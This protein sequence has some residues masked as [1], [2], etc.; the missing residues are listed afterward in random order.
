MKFDYTGAREAGYSDGDIVGFLEQKGAKFDFGAARAAGYSD[1]D[2]AGYIESNHDQVFGA[3]EP[4]IVDRAVT[5]GKRIAKSTYIG[6]KLALEEANPFGAKTRSVTG[7]P[8]SEKDLRAAQRENF[9]DTREAPLSPVDRAVAERAGPVSRPFIEA[10]RRNAAQ[11]Q[12]PTQLTPEQEAQFKPWYADIA[13]KGGLDPNPDDPRHQYDY[14]G[15]FLAG[16]QP[17]EDGHLDSRFKAPGHPNRFVDG[18]DT[19]TGQPVDESV[20]A[21]TA[22]AVNAQQSKTRQTLDERGV[23]PQET[24]E[25][26]LSRAGRARYKTVKTWDFNRSE[27]MSMLKDAAEAGD[28]HAS[29]ALKELTGTADNIVEAAAADLRKRNP[30]LAQS[31]SQSV[32]TLGPMYRQA[33]GGAGMYIGAAIGD[34]LAIHGGQIIAAEAKRDLERLAKEHGHGLQQQVANSVTQTLGVM[35][36]VIASSPVFGGGVE[37]VLGT[38]SSVAGAQAYAEGLDDGL[39]PN[40]AATYAGLTALIEYATEKIPTT[41]L[42]KK[43]PSFVKKAAHVLVR[44]YPSEYAATALEAALDKLTKNPEMTLREFSQQLAVTTLAVPISTGALAAGTHAA[45]RAIGA[46]VY[47]A[48][49]KNT[50]LPPAA[51]APLSASAVLGAP[52]EQAPD[53]ASGSATPRQPDPGGVES[54]LADPKAIFAA[55]TQRPAILHTIQQA[56][57]D[58]PAVAPE[59][60]PD[61]AAALKAME[62]DPRSIFAIA[63]QHP[64]IFDTI[65]KAAKASGVQATAPSPTEAPAVPPAASTQAPAYESPQQSVG[66]AHAQAEADRERLRDREIERLATE[67]RKHRM[68]EA[69]SLELARAEA[70]GSGVRPEHKST[71]EHALER[72]TERAA[73][74]VARGKPYGLSDKTLQHI[75]GKD[76]MIGERARAELARRAA[77]RESQVGTTGGSLLSRPAGIARLQAAHPQVPMQA[78]APEH[79]PSKAKRIEK[80]L[81]AAFNKKVVFVKADPA[82]FEGQVFTDDPSTVYINVDANRSLRKVTGHELLH[83]LKRTNQRVYANLLRS[84]RQSIDLDKAGA[85]ENYYGE[86]RPAKGST[87]HIEEMVGDIF[88][89]MMDDPKFWLKVFHAS[90]KPLVKKLYDAIRMLLDVLRMKLRIGERRSGYDTREI[91][92]DIEAVRKA[93]AQAYA[94][95]QSGAETKSAPAREA[96]VALQSKPDIHVEV[97]KRAEQTRQRV[98]DRD[99]DFR[100]SKGDKILSNTGRSYEILFR[101]LVGKEHDKPAYRVKSLDGE[102]SFD[103]HEEAAS[104]QLDAA[105]QSLFSLPFKR[106]F[107]ERVAA[108]ERADEKTKRRIAAEPVGVLKALPQALD[109]LKR[110]DGTRVFAKSGVIGNVSTIYEKG[111]GL[112]RSA[113]EGRTPIPREM[114]SNLDDY[115]KDPLAV[116]SPPKDHPHADRVWLLLGKLGREYASVVIDPKSQYGGEPVNM[117]VSTTPRTATA[118]EYARKQGRVLYEKEAPQARST[119]GERGVEAADSNPA[120]GEGEKPGGA[121]QTGMVSKTLPSVKP[122]VDEKAHEA[123]TSPKNDKP[124]PTQ[125]QKQAGNYAKGHV[126]VA[127]M[128]I[129]I[130]NPEGSVRTFIRPDGVIG[131]TRL[132]AHYG[133][134][135][136]T[137]GADGDHLDIFIKPGTPHAYEGPVFVADQTKSDS[138]RF[139]EHKVLLGWESLA[140]A[141]A[142]YKENYSKGWDGLESIVRFD[143]VADFKTWKDEGNLDRRAARDPAALLSRPARRAPELTEE[144]KKDLNFMKDRAYDAPIEETDPLARHLEQQNQ[145]L[146]QQAERELRGGERPG[147]RFYPR[148][149]WSKR[150]NI[151]DWQSAD[152]RYMIEQLPGRQFVLKIDGQEKFLGHDRMSAIHAAIM[153][154]H[155]DLAAGKARSPSESVSVAAQ[156]PEPVRQR[157]AQAWQKLASFKTIFRFPSSAKKGIDGILADMGQ[158]KLVAAIHDH[159]GDVNKFFKIEFFDGTSADL[160]LH[161]DGTAHL[162]AAELNEG[163]QLGPVLYQAVL[164]WAK[165]NK[166]VL[167]PDPAGLSYINSYRRTEQMLSAALRLGTSAYMRPHADQGLYGWIE[168]PKSQ[169]DEDSNIA[170]MAITSMRSVMEHVP[171]VPS[172]RYDF[173][174]RRFEEPPN[175]PILKADLDALGASKPARDIGAGRSTLARAIFTQSLLSDPQGADMLIEGAVT[176]ALVLAGDTGQSLALYSNPGERFEKKGPGLAKGAVLATAKAGTVIARPLAAALDIANTAADFVAKGPGKLLAYPTSRLYDR[177]VSGVSNFMKKGELR[178]QIAHGTTAD[179]GLPEPYL[180]KRDDRDIDIQKHLRQ[181]KQMIDH[182]AALDDAESMV[183]YQWM[184]E[185]PSTAEEARLLALLPEGSKKTL[186]AMKDFIDKLGREA[187]ALGLMSQETYDRNAMAYLHRSYK[188]YEVENPQA[189]ASSQ[190]AKALRADSFRGRGLRDD[191]ALSRLPGVAKGDHYVRLEE[192]AAQPTG[193]LGRL[194]R[195][196]YIRAGQPIPASYSTWRNDGVWEARFIDKAGQVGL[197]RD[198]TRDERERLGEIREVRYAFARTMIGLVHDIETARFLKW[199]MENY[200][201]SDEGGVAEK[202]GTVAD[203][204]DK[205]TTLKTYGDKDWVQVPGTM[206]QGTRLYKYGLLQSRYIPGHI[207]ND[208]RATI[209]VR[210]GQAVWKLYDGLLRA[211]KISKTALSP[212]VHTNNVMSNF[213]FLDLAE[214]KHG[215]L[216]TA[217]QTLIDAERGNDTARAMLERYLDSGAEL[218]TPALHELRKEVIEPLLGKLQ[219][220]ENEVL[221]HLSLIQA[222]SL[223]ARGNVRQALAGMAASKLVRIPLKP[224][225]VMIAAYQL[226]DSVFRLAKWVKETQGGMSDRDAGKAAREAFLDYRINA[227]WIAALRRGPFPFLAFTYRA[228]PLLAEGF[229]KKPWKLLKYMAAGYAMNALAYAMLGLGGKDEDKER[230]LLPEEKSGHTILGTPRLMRMPWNDDHGEPV[231]LDIRRWIPGGDIFDISGSHGAIPTPSWLSLGGYWGLAVELASNKSQFTGQLIWK[232]S[233]TMGERV[234]KV[235]DHLFKFLAPNLPLPNPLGYPLDA[236]VA[237][238]GLLQTYSWKT[239]QNAGGGA[240]DDFGRERSVPQAIASAVG[241]K[242]ASYPKDQLQRNLNAQKAHEIRDLDETTARYKREFRRGGLTSKEFEARMTK[243]AEK[244]QEINKRYGEKLGY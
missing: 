18:I 210:S 157:V 8:A 224:F 147:A 214:V 189:V 7:P 116:I 215:H 16:A 126:R 9:R 170:L 87:V 95:W 159:V 59:A 120:R 82:K 203:A 191:V 162:N 57:A 67:A 221:A 86:G 179:Y 218:G 200:S 51:D 192:R 167:V 1:K 168:Q 63:T 160:V 26:R 29:Y 45:Q 136:G 140:D 169:A 197:W 227:P 151:G 141:R 20:A 184:Q 152:G 24:P 34:N 133:Y 135:R 61:V 97:R 117:I 239:I 174:K 209:N 201:V 19:I 145:E 90:E 205:M 79:L 237:E 228:V 219:G 182:I 62:A 14:R 78:V 91:I 102:T 80:L 103:L 142:A 155:E 66:A 137:E 75:A 125:A 94:D 71:M 187:V 25:E 21:R 105:D 32:D 13:A 199:T 195:V 177:L 5:E 101:N 146:S 46:P 166:V 242:L 89:D 196:I 39:N 121:A 92:K 165:N 11:G 65:A 244:R 225:Q 115:V 238:K 129:S 98:E 158:A 74:D 118:V 2:I 134:I 56:V 161:S 99:A 107:E 222:V 106:H 124:E 96:A 180:E 206:A 10:T 93:A 131:S 223:A 127:G 54:L 23:L 72:G 31:F 150:P 207:W 194:K 143:S 144:E 119:S 76:G 172:M 122:P 186:G 47:D 212:V 220:E 128:D 229:A 70:A 22:Q 55:V 181:S 208:I 211:W 231:F 217:L 123:A 84:I 113:E 50:E 53:P 163:S 243:Q 49:S 198:L 190:R 233:D 185:R 176:P 114:L 213:I 110:P 171:D 111:A 130:E 52:E 154:F 43:H 175:V 4:G 112:H 3:E 153:H 42:L 38:M 40:Q 100:F 240:T 234:A 193:G 64:E 138:N 156:Y 104:M 28:I 68:E 58:M 88:G 164:V 178:Q 139:D 33:M 235:M 44:E 60:R 232:D 41:E 226:E 241:V 202:G 183:A 188:K 73:A 48:P 77:H 37:Y 6:T 85:Y 108:Y 216:I 83:T 36:P 35:V 15:A 69:F 230:A 132:K 236:A 27:K 12:R 204:V 81:G 17:G 173:E 148:L 149:E 30:T 109:F